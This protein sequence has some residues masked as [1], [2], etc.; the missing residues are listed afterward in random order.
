MTDRTLTNARLVMYDGPRTRIVDGWLRIADGRIADWGEGASGGE[1]MGGRLITPAL[2]D[3]H[4]HLVHGGDRARE[5]EMR[6]EG[7]S[8]EQIARAGGG[9]LSTVTHTR[10]A[11]E[12]ELVAAALPRLDTLL[13]EGVCTVEIKSGY[14]L[15]ID[16]ELKMLR[17]ARRLAAE[18]PVRIVTTWLAAHALPPEYADRS[19][20]YIDEIAIAGLRAAH[21]AGLV[22]AVDGF[23]ENIAFSV[24]QMARVFDVATE[25]GLPV[26]LHAEQ[27]SHQGGS[28]LVAQ[29][30]GLSADHVEYADA[31]DAA[32]LAAAGSVATLLPGAYYTL[33]ET[34]MPPIQAFR[35]AGTTMALATDSNPG[36][37]PLTSLLLAMNMGATLFRLTP[38]ECLRGVTCNAARA[39]GLGDCGT[40]APGLARRSG[41]LG[42]ETPGRADLSHRL[43]PA[44]PPLFQGP[45]MLTL[46]PGDATL[47]QLETMWRSGQPARLD[48]AARPA[49]EVSAGRIA[50]AAAGDAAV[51]GVNTGFGKLAS[52]RIAAGRHRDAAAQ[53]DPVALLRRRSGAGRGPPCG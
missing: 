41:R 50:A 35:D 5:F 28:L 6:L 21:G 16:D 8:Y 17:A 20:A 31:A 7:A 33:R 39:L 11:T 48:A 36:T 9:I 43:Q 23:C 22:D 10:S 4:T 44:L 26:K 18:R 25:L 2:I 38:D 27:L 1:D 29:R 37:S 47:A 3:C 13:A 19:D 45:P 40:L 53:P 30:G 24:D 34:Q 15:T 12:D 52:V 14:G 49:I 42:R 32:A 51:Y 46:T